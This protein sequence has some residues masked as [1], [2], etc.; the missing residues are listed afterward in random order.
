[1]PEVKAFKAIR[2][3]NDL[4]ENL[5]EL[6]SPPYDVIK[7]TER[8]AMLDKNKFNS[9]KLCLVEDLEDPDRYKK[10]RKEF[11]DWKAEGVLT[12]TD[13]ESFYL[14]EDTY[15]IEGKPSKRIGFVGLL[16][17]SPFEEKQVLPHEYTMSG[18]K[19]DRLALLEAMGAEFSQIF[20]CYQDPD[21]V[22]EKIYEEKSKT[23]PDLEGLD[24]MD[25]HRRVWFI[26]DKTQLE[27]IQN[28]LADKQLLIADGHH[29]YETAIYY[30]KNGPSEKSKYVQCYFTNSQNPDFNILPIHRIT[31]LPEGMSEFDF[32][33]R[34][35][36]T[37]KLSQL[38]PNEDFRRTIENKSNNE[39]AFI[40]S[41]ASSGRSFLLSRPKKSSTDAEIFSL[42]KQIF[43]DIYG[44]DVSKIA[45]GVIQFEH[46]TSDFLKTLQSNERNVGF[47]LP[48]TDLSLILDVV[49]EGRRMPQKS[50]FFYP[51]L[52]SGLVNYELGNG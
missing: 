1:M 29:R 43:E 18:P 16:K 42:Q 9:V 17:T 3:S 32:Q 30:A 36:K 2:Y 28:C 41:F 48:S 14:I 7:E 49:K 4:K 31:H 27:A 33:G 40:C 21:F 6:I 46:T 23:A 19:K 47:F 34:L 52:A 44:W 5:G 24:V 45:K 20:M 50:T 11:E 10:M 12:Q 35:E 25:V 8:K 26:Q 15:E 51:K 13:R 38:Q 39:I 22:L 37:F